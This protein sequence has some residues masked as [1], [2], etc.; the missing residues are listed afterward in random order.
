LITFLISVTVVGT[1]LI[2]VMVVGV[3]MM[4]EE[5]LN[6]RFS[7]LFSKAISPFIIEQEERMHENN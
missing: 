7:G 1:G 5:V 3:E 6:K 4:K 2:S